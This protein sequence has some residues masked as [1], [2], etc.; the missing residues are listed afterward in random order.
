MLNNQI[1]TVFEA[2]RARGW[3]AEPDAKHLLAAA[4]LTVPRFTTV[5]EPGGIESAAA[6]IG[7]PLAAKAVIPT[8][9]PQVGSRRREDGYFHKGGTDSYI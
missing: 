5:T 7:F 2:S 3:V 9:P 1:K 8:G 6:S 4:G